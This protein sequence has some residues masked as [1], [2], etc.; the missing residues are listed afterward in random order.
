MEVKRMK[1]KNKLSQFLSDALGGIP[2]R[3]VYNALV[4][5]EESSE[6]N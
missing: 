1:N 4:K 2:P 3:D 5:F 6:S